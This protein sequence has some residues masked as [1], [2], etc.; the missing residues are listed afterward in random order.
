M[1][2]DYCASVLLEAKI[3]APYVF[4]REH[5]ICQLVDDLYDYLKSRLIV[6]EP[7]L[8]PIDNIRS[9]VFTFYSFLDEWKYQ[10]SRATQGI[11]V[12]DSLA[13]MTMK[14]KTPVLYNVFSSYLPGLSSPAATRHMRQSTCYI[15]PPALE[16]H[17]VYG[18]FCLLTHL[19]DWIHRTTGLTSLSCGLPDHSFDVPQLALQYPLMNIPSLRLSDFCSTLTLDDLPDA[20]PAMMALVSFSRDHEANKT[21]W[22]SHRTSNL[23][24]NVNGTRLTTLNSWMSSTFE[25]TYVPKRLLVPHEWRIL[26]TYG[27]PRTAWL[28]DSAIPAPRFQISNENLDYEYDYSHQ[29]T[30]IF[31]DL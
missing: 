20:D 29:D 2:V 8:V 9:L 31:D 28:Q 3:D 21:H 14:T 24:I 19:Y 17:F 27:F 13:L 26:R 5:F 4:P 10:R 30:S 22:F 23:G 18:S 11:T 25:T 1:N 6:P 16:T 12:P 7:G 15:L